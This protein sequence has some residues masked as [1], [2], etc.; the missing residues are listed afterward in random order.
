MLM[1]TS[2]VRSTKHIPVLRYKYVVSH[3]TNPEFSALPLRMYL[4]CRTE[5]ASNTS[6]NT[7][8]HEKMIQM[9]VLN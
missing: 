4:A 1:E 5:P 7:I 9:S 2:G 8:Q 6:V 3:E